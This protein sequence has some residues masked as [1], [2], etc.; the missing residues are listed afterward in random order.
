MSVERAVV[1]AR[2]VAAVVE[3]PAAVGGIVAFER[4]VIQGRAAEVVV[5]PAAVVVRPRTRSISV[6]DHQVLKDR[7]GGFIAV[8]LQHAVGIGTIDDGQRSPIGIRN[9][10][11]GDRLAERIH[12]R[13]LEVRASLKLDHIIRV[14]HSNRHVDRLGAARGHVQIIIDVVVDPIVVEVEGH[15]IVVIVDAI[16]VGVVIQWIGAVGHL[17]AV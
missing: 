4:A 2:V 15:A 10:E 11:N 8:A 9:P 12:D 17:L 7:R 5:H 6:S 1:Q 3:H 13:A 16:A 14:R